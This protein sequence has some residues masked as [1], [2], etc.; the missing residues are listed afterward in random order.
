[1]QVSSVVRC[2]SLALLILVI[3]IS[4]FAGVLVS[5]TIAPP[6]LPVY[7]QPA[8]PGDGYIWTPGYWPMVRK[9]ITGYLARGYSLP[10]LVCSGHPDIGAGTKVCMCG[11]RGIGGL[12]SVFMVG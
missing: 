5:V 1:M 7:T 6:V 4:S 2:F 3:P 8:C 10:W 9:A 11:I 12:I